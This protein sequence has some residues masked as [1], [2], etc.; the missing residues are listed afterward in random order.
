MFAAAAV[1]SAALLGACPAARGAPIPT[2]KQLDKQLTKYKPRAGLEGPTNAHL[3]MEGLPFYCL[4]DLFLSVMLE[5]GHARH[6]ETKQAWDRNYAAFQKQAALVACFMGRDLFPLLITTS[7]QYAVGFQEGSARHAPKF[8]PADYVRPSP[9]EI[10]KEGEV[11]RVAWWHAAGDADGDGVSNADELR[12]VAPE[13]GPGKGVTEADRD[14]FVEAALGCASWRTRAADCAASGGE[15]ESEASDVGD[16]GGED[17]SEDVRRW[18][19]IF[20]LA[21]AYP[22]LESE[23]LIGRFFNTPMRLL[24][25]GFE[26]VTTFGDLRDLSLLVMPNLGM[27][28]VVS[29]RVAVFLELGYGAGPV[30]TKAND[31][32]IFLFPLHTDFEMKR[33]AFVVVPGVD[34]FPFG[35]VEQREYH[36]LKDRLR[37]AKPMLG[38]RVPWTYASYEAYVKVGFKPFGNLVS[39]KKSDAW[40]I[41]SVNANVGVDVPVSKHHQLNFNAGHSFFAERDYD[42][43]GPTWS[44]SWK[45]LF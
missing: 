10:L 39:V 5:P 16:G 36:G 23:R 27:G 6:A 14:R 26:D 28:Y 44:V 45:Y 15:A 25:P 31:A 13:W 29:K 1:M 42:F 4:F 33:A 2:F 37:G 32:S 8:N 40:R 7:E 12:A 11:D 19:V 9:T 41:W 3:D 35:M 38:L 22:A 43:G 30:R 18:F 20:T 17:S 21:N 24:A 34:F